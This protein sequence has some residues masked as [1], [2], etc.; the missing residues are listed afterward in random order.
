MGEVLRW[1]FVLHN[2]LKLGHGGIVVAGDGVTVEIADMRLAAVRVGN[3]D[4]DFSHA[5]FDVL[6]RRIKQRARSSL[7]HRR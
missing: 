7:Q 4:G 5:G 1:K 2:A 6:A 3:G